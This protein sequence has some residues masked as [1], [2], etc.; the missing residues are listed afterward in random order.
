MCTLSLLMLASMS[1]AG[2]S[3]TYIEAPTAAPAS[4]YT[5]PQDSN[6]VLQVYFDDTSVTNGSYADSWSNL[7]WGVNS[8]TQA[9]GTLRPFFTSISGQECAKFDGSDDYITFGDK[10]AFSMVTGVQDVAFALEVW[11]Y[12]TN[13]DACTW[14]GKVSSGN[15]EWYVYT[16]A[17]ERINSVH[18]DRDGVGTHAQYSLAAATAYTLSNWVHAVYTTDGTESGQKWYINGTNLGPANSESAYNYMTNLTA[19]LEFGR[20][21]DASPNYCSHYVYLIRLWNQAGLQTNDVAN[22]YTN[23]AAEL[24]L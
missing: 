21:N 5:P 13:Y 12:P 2:V 1:M 11:F 23:G 14:F 20:E 4:T 19:A 3:W 6:L 18:Y 9:N 8:A 16:L 15:L 22:L 17:D 10:D 7:L 24:G